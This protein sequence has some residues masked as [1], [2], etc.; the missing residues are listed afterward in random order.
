MLYPRESETREIKD[1]SGAWNFKIDKYNR[2]FIDKWYESPLTDTMLMPVP[3]SYNDIT[4]SIEIRDHIGWAWYEKDFFIPASWKEQRIVVRVG[5]ACHHAV[6][7]VNGREIVSHKGGYLPFEADITESV[8]VGSENRINIAVNNIL[9]WTTMPPGEIKEYKDSMHPEGYKTQEYH[10]DFFNY[11]GIH[12]PVKLYITPKNYID[13]IIVNTEVLE[14]SGIVNYKLRAEGCV[15]ETKVSL[16]DKAGTVV[17]SAIG[18]SGKLKVKEPVLWEPGKAYLYTLKAELISEVGNVEDCYRLPVGIRTV[19]VTEKEF[20][21]NGKP[22]Y[23]RGFGKHEDMDIKGKGLD[24]AV[25]IKDFNLLKWIGA[26]SVRTSHYPYSE[27][28]MNLADRLGIVVVDETTAVGMNFWR[29]DIKVFSEERIHREALDHHLQVVRELIERDRNHP[30]VV[31][32][33][34]ANEAATYEEGAVPYFEELATL[35][36]YIDNTRPITIVMNADP[37]SDK[38]GHL[39]DVICVNRYFS[40]YNDPGHLELIEYQLEKD[41]TKWFN[42]YR[43]PVFLTEYGADAIAGMHSNPPVMFS[44]EYQCESVKHYHNVFDR[45]DFVVGEHVWA[46]ADFATKQGIT[47]VMG[48][49]KGVF[50]RERQPKSIAFVLKDRW[51]K[52]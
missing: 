34:I 48:N 15:T 29:E 42:R 51:S 21:I 13:S 39:V 1:I 23:F 43:K 5:S 30:C 11:A 10:H 38:V 18:S 52:R 44:E 14:E 12:R 45:S 26:N 27:E 40:W 22:F 24:E 19:M 6:L 25:L 31:M 47:R 16:L 36:R 3:A 9:D 37:L 35:T 7:W 33:S 41:I 32:W 17:A 4:Q 20:L 50:T 49:K 2:G 8:L 46:F 28:F